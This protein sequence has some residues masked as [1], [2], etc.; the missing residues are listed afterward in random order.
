MGAKEMKDVL[1][2]RIEQADER[3]LQV[4]F[5]MVE[6]YAEQYQAGG[7]REVIGYQAGGVAITVANLK[8]KINRAEEQIDRGEYHSL[9]QLRKESEQWLSENTR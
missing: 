1:H 8:A 4:I 3:F 5:A 2:Y 6:A 7:E 9:E